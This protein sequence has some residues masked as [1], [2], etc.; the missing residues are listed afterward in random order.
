MGKRKTE[1]QKQNRSLPCVYLSQEQGEF[2]DRQ[3]GNGITLPY[4]YIVREAINCLPVIVAEVPALGN[5]KSLPYRLGTSLLTQSLEDKLEQY[6]T[7]TGR[8]Q[9]QCVRDAIQIYMLKN[10]AAH[11]DPKDAEPVKIHEAIPE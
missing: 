11:F 4:G 9:S 5:S 2:M 10:E 1:E 3:T 8:K 7:L 6:K